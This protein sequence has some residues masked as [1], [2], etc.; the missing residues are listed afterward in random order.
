MSSFA[1]VRSRGG[2]VGNPK[3]FPDYVDFAFVARDALADSNDEPAKF[4]NLADETVEAPVDGFELLADGL[5]LLVD[6]FEALVDVLVL[7]VELLVD[8][9]ELLADKS[10]LSVET[11]VHQLE[12]LIVELV[13]SVKTMT[14]D[15]DEGA[16]GGD[17]RSKCDKGV[18]VFFEVS[19]HQVGSPGQLFYARKLNTVGLRRETLGIPDKWLFPYIVIV[20]R[21]LELSV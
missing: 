4:G 8:G 12:Q 16:E 10:V 15:H 1:E 7:G 6:G 11:L 9:F 19:W 20:R 3:L 2:C 21:L 17:D 13:L 5:E 14:V 18:S